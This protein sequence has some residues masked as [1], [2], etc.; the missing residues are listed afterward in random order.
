MLHLKSEVNLDSEIFSMYGQVG[1]STLRIFFNHIIFIMIGKIVDFL[2]AFL[3][4]IEV[5]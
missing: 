3:G 1:Q 5:M 2:E 4:V